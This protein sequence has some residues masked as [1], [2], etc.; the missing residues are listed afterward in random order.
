M[1]YARRIRTRICEHV[2]IFWWSV[3]G[4]ELV[5]YCWHEYVMRSRLAQMH[6][7]YKNNEPQYRISTRGRNARSTLVMNR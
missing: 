6:V 1:K 3:E 5:S 4:Q 2:S 7:L